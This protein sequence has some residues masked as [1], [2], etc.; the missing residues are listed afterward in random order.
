VSPLD[1]SK[2]NVI[3]FALTESVA[4]INPR[5][6]EIAELPFIAEE[7]VSLKCDPTGASLF[8]G[9]DSGI[10][11]I[12]DVETSCGISQFEFLESGIIV[13]DWK[14]NTI[15][16]GS[17]EGK[18][19][20]MDVRD[21]C[22]IRVQEAHLEQL[23]S[24]R[25]HPDRP[26]LATC[27]NDCSVKIWDLRGLGS[28]PL[29]IYGEHEAAIRAAAWSP[30]NPDIIATGGG[31][32]DRK[33]KLWNTVTGETIK[34]VDTGSQVC[35]L[36]WHPGYKEIL[37]SHGFSQNHLALWKDQE[38]NPIASFHSHKQRILFLAASPDGS[39][40]VTAA[41]GDSLQIWKMFPLQERSM[42]HSLLLLR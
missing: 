24:V 17:R 20:V 13:S 37:S 2:K 6:L 40:I 38:L 32:A 1:W 18:F 39:T 21:D 11:Q 12:Y 4:L 8:L 25:L 28:D 22:S 35:N 19:V 42:S 29:M 41:P 14:D 7:V 16:S 9:A 36:F 5:T 10:A 34:S 33:V 30:T 31:T 27:G 23:C 15:V 26:L 3:A